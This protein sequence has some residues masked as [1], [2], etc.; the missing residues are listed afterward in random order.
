MFAVEKYMAD[1][2]WDGLLYLGDLMDFDIISSHNKNNL[3]AVEGR[4]MSDEYEYG[5]RFL[6]RHRKIVGKNTKMVLLE[7][8]HDYRAEAYVDANPVVEGMFEVENGLGLKERGVEWIRTWSEGKTYNIGNAKFHHG[9][10]TSQYHAR[11]M[12]DVFGTNIFYGHTHDVQAFSREFEGDDK[13]IVGQSMGCLCE[14]KQKYMRGKPS[15]W[16][17]AFGV[18]HFFPDGF[19]TYFVV[20]V[21]KNRFVSPEGQ[22][23]DGDSYVDKSK[24]NVIFDSLR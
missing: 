10:Y 1:H 21:F 14:I 7:G 4:R 5:R 9:L 15:K 18:F 17:Q 22:V 11:K 23:Y 16:Q 19:F 2:K 20:R 6:D 12:A 13:T 8:N 24:K 3:R